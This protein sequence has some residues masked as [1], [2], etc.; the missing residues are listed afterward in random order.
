MLRVRSLKYLGIFRATLGLLLM[1]MIQNKVGDIRLL[2]GIK[3]LWIF[4]AISI[5]ITTRARFCA[6]K[7]ES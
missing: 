3:K 7:F 1:E 5:T 4:I 6:I 2:I